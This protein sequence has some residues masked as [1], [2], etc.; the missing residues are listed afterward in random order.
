MSDRTVLVA[1]DTSAAARPVLDAARH[2]AVVVDGSLDAVHVSEDRTMTPRATASW[3]GATLRLLEPPVDEA[4]LRAAAAPEVVMVVVGARSTPLGRR[5]AGHTA[6]R[7]MEG[8]AKPLAVVPPEADGTR[9]VQRVVVPLE[10]T[11]SSSAAILDALELLLIAPVSVVALHVFTDVTVPRMMD[12]P[13]RDLQMIGAE[14]RTRHLP[15]ASRVEFRTGSVDRGV[16][17][18]CASEDADLV[19]LSW[20]RIMSEGRAAVVRGVLSQCR[21]PVLLLPLSVD[22]SNRPL[23][24]V[25]ARQQ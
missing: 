22:P 8:L 20:S 17:E 15:A 7:L 13:L 2:L 19:V 5:P 14:F 24:T 12:R 16:V 3:A 25:P 18:L 1:L 21:V 6:L 11:E 23:D 9:R 4:L 10:G